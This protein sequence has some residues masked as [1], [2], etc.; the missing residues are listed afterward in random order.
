[1][2]TVSMMLNQDELNELIY[3]LGK[4]RNN[5]LANRK[6]SDALEVRMRDALDDLN[7][8]IVELESEYNLSRD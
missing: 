6:V 2:I 1:M 7:D 8:A 4:N 5:K 3:A